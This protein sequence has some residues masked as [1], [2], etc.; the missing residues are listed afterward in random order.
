MYA[1]VTFNFTGARI[2]KGAILPSAWEV[3]YDLVA[4][5]GSSDE[6]VNIII[7]K[8]QYFFDTCMS[9]IVI[10][11]I[12]DDISIDITNRTDNPFMLLPE[13]VS[14]EVI[15]S[16]LYSKVTAIVGNEM[17]VTGSGYFST[18]SV[19]SYTLTEVPDYFPKKVDEYIDP[20]K[21]V[22]MYSDVWWERNDGYT[23]ELLK[24]VGDE[25]PF[26]ALYADSDPFLVFDETISEMQDNAPPA[27]K[28]KKVAKVS[29]WTPRIV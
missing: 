28:E 8:L 14:H 16:L 24:K 7:S 4:R 17:L 3:S 1:T 25:T 20:L 15:A 10:V 21:M 27:P 26:D 12:H 2:D 19:V 5:P 13:A 11:D 18:D 23:G 22:S 9:N 6:K 29:K